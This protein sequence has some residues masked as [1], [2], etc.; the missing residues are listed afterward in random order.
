MHNPIADT[1]D[2][3]VFALAL[4][5]IGLLAAAP[6]KFFDSYFPKMKPLTY[7]FIF[8]IRLLAIF[9][10]IGLLVAIIL[11]LTELAEHHTYHSAR[12][13]RDERRL[14]WFCPKHCIG[15]A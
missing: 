5:I 9:C 10:F 2:L 8:G 13:E 3:I 7:G 14:L 6:E 1:T 12:G 4:I 11:Y 15:G